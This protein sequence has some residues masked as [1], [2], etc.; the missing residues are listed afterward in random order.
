MREHKI[1]RSLLIEQVLTIE[2]ERKS[3]RNSG[4]GK[5]LLR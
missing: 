5:I 2:V 3:F 1:K 4:G